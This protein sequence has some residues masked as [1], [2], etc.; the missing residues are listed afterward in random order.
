LAVDVIEFVLMM[1]LP[2]QLQWMAIH[3]FMWRE[4]M[5]HES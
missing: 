2:V 5:L 1:N 3:L 4:K